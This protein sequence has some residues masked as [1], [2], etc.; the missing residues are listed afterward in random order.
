MKN[1]AAAIPKIFAEFCVCACD[2]FLF[3]ITS[4]AKCNIAHHFCAINRTQAELNIYSMFATIFA[5]FKKQFIVLNT[6]HSKYLFH[7]K[8][9]CY[10]FSHIQWVLDEYGLVKIWNNMWNQCDKHRNDSELVKSALPCA[11][12]LCIL[13]TMC[14]FW[15]RCHYHFSLYVQC[16]HRASYIC[17]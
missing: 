2:T 17:N 11:I 7:S 10:V 9:I 16:S 3:W 14:T 4:G 12:E 1:V 13:C 15:C 8:Q 6:F 5:S